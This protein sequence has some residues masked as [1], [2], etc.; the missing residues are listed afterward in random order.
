LSDQRQLTRDSLFVTAGI[1]AEGLD[2]D[3][4]VRVR[5]LSAG[6]MMAEGALRVRRGQPLQVNL[7]NIGWI[8]GSVAWIEGDRTGIA[9]T[10]E[11]NPK[12]VRA[13][14]GG[15]SRPASALAA[16]PATGMRKI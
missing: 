12:K 15:Y 1:R 2:G 16:S 11:I 10:V 3:V 9:F 7:R 6:G 8:E 14:V 13:P 5:N 4:V